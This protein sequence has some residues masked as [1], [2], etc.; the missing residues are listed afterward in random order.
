MLLVP[1]FLAL[2]LAA[3]GAT[4]F[5]YRKDIAG[6]QRLPFALSTSVASL[7]IVVVIA[8]IG[9]GSYAMNPDI[10]AALAGAALL[11]VLLFTTIAGALLRS[12]V[13]ADSRVIAQ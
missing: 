4:V 1:V 3:R 2:F 10:A 5:L 11:S 13:A 9:T 8:E 12:G 6:D 7:S